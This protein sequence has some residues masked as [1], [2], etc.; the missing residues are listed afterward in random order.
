M[1]NDLFQLVRDTGVLIQTF[2]DD[3]V[4]Y[5]VIDRQDS[6]ENALGDALKHGETNG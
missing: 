5:K 4:I 6:L 3:I 2:A 1:L